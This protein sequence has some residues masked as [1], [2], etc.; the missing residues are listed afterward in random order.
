M[1]KHFWLTIAA[2]LVF[3][4]G[5]IAAVHAE[6][7]PPH[8]EG[9]IGLTAVVLCEKLTVRREPAA[10]AAAAETL[11]YGD[12]IILQNLE[13]GWAECFLS[14]AEGAGP[15]GWVNTDYLAVDPTWYVTDTE[16]PVYAWNE[17]TAPRVALLD[18]G[19]TLPV[20]KDD[21]GWLV[22]SLRGASGWIP[23]P[24]AD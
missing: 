6:I 14:D 2:L 1:K 19:T 7:L 16:T 8:G 11:H 17:Q 22:V 15:A 24:A 4:L 13:N 10:G 20:L 9:Q 12:R 18:K 5:S 23:K 3:T 21:G